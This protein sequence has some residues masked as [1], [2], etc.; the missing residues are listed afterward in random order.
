M[1]TPGLAGEGFALLLLPVTLT[2][3]ALNFV[4]D[5]MRDRFV[6]CSEAL[7]LPLRWAF[8][9]AMFYFLLAVRPFGVL[10]NAYFRF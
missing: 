8:W 3:L 5:A 4:G 9:L 10:P 7:P 1:F 2:G 6:R